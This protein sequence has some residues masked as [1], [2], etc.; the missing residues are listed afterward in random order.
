VL[1]TIENFGEI[2]YFQFDTEKDIYLLFGKNSV[3]KSYAISLVY[4]I[5]KTDLKLNNS[6]S[7]RKKRQIYYLPFFIQN[8]INVIL[9]SLNQLKLKPR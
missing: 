4:L 6:I 5:L 9:K 1:I 8:S 7:S 2:K 3:G